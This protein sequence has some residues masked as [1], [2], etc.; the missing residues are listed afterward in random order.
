MYRKTE[1]QVNRQA[2][3]QTKELYSMYGYRKGHSETGMIFSSTEN[4]KME[5]KMRKEMLAENV[6]RSAMGQERESGE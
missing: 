4:R 1:I 3:R 2:G 5:K 6:S